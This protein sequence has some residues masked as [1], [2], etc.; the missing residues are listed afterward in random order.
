MIGRSSCKVVYEKQK[1]SKIEQIF[2]VYAYV[3]EF[4]ELLPYFRSDIWQL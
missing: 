2:V 4:L 3:S 1:K